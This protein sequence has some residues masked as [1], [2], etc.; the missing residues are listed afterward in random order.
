MRFGVLGTVGV[1]HGLATVRPPKARSILAALLLNANRVVPMDLLVDVV[2]GDSPPVKA[3]ASLHNHVARLRTLVI[4]A[5]SGRIETVA[6]GYLVEVTA[7][8]LDLDEFRRLDRAGRGALAARD[9]A[10]ASRQLSAALALWRGEPLAD[11][12]SALL[13]EQEIPQL[14]QLRLDALEARIDADL[15]LGRHVELT[16]ELTRLTAVYPLRERFHTQLM[17]AYAR[18]DRQAE[19]LSAF[20]RARE[21]LAEELGADPGPELRLLHQQILT[22]NLPPV[23]ASCPAG[24]IRPAQL[25]AGLA[26]FT[27]R[28]ADAARLATVADRAAE[29]P[30]VVPVWVVTGPGGI[31]KTSLAVQVGHQVRDQF[32]DG[33]LYAHLG[34]GGACPVPPGQALERFLRDLGVDPGQA[35]PGE[36]GQAAQFRSALAGR[37]VLIVLDDARDSGQVTPLLPGS[38]GCAVIVTSRSQLADLPGVRRLRLEPL[39]QDQSVDLLSAIIGADRVRAEAQVA[40]EI[41]GLCGGL[42]LALRIAGSRLATRPHWRLAD[43]AARLTRDGGCLDELAVGDMSVRASFAISYGRLATGPARPSPAQAF[44]LLGRWS[45]PDISLPAAAALLGT[46]LPTAEQALEALLE[47]HL[48]EAAPSSLGGRYRLPG[49]LGAYAAERARA[50]EP[51]DMLHDALARL[52]SWYWHSTLAAAS[53]ITPGI[54]PVPACPPPDGIRPWIAP[55]ADQAARWLAVELPNLH[56]VLREAAAREEHPTARQLAAILRAVHRRRYLTATRVGSVQ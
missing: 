51:P 2:W 8:D 19:A 46:D 13:R 24:T 39:H 35:P 28:A 12:T 50:Q 45:G 5:G 32:P 14:A 22:G 20:Q 29:R 31:G 33:Q 52:L 1:G 41:V 4:Q 21:L 56:A 49:L 43:L 11:V 30:G 47:A 54:V 18:S 15:S 10:A 48:L 16:A 34:G 55:S 23:N 9:W 27:G 37:R 26:D 6:P 36:S 3:V 42:P 40:E 17:L 25:P 44:R 7:G 38:A 53:V